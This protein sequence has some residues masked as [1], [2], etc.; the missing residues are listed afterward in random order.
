MSGKYNYLCYLQ[1]RLAYLKDW[2]RCANTYRKFIKI[3]KRVEKE[4][5]K[6]APFIYIIVFFYF[7]PINLLKFI[8]N[9]QRDYYYKKVK[10]EIKIVKEEIIALQLKNK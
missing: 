10:N 6:E 2:V 1:D 7:I 9:I 8:E 4:Q 5:F 3:N